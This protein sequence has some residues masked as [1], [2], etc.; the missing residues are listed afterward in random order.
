V[1]EESVNKIALHGFDWRPSY[2]VEISDFAPPSHDGFAF[3]S[4]VVEPGV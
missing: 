1:R 4:G 3:F 2:L